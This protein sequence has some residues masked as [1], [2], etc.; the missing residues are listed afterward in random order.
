MIEVLAA[1][2]LAAAQAPAPDTAGLGWLS[3][4]WQGP[5]TMFGNASTAR[6]EVRPALG[7]RFLEL[8]WRAGGFEGRAFY[9]P[10]GEGRWRATWFDNRGLSFPVEA[11]L[12]GRTLSA[13][14]GSAETERGR[15]VYRLLPD[16]RLEVTDTAGGRDFARHVLGRAE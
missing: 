5:G 8:S 16:G 1:F 15:T 10:V 14:W 9:R 11:V 13:D 4:S 12:A 3:G 6:L 2:A 7:G